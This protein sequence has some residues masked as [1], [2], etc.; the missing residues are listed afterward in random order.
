M[1]TCIHTTPDIFVQLQPEWNTLLHNS[2]ADT[3]FLT[4]GWQK[5]WSDCLCSCEGELHLLTVRDSGALLGLA[6]LFAVLEPNK[7]GRPQRLLRLIGS[8][9]ASDYLD[10]IAVRGRECE[11]LE[12]MLDALSQSAEWDVLDLYNVP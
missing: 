2:A 9:D 12:A 8:V 4:Y 1:E 5:T 11:V 6:P 3:P 10:L 7:D